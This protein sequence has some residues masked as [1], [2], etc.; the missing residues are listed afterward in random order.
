LVQQ[1]QTNVVD[2][3]FPIVRGQFTLDLRTLPVRG[4][5]GAPKRMVKLFD[6]TC[7]HCRDLH[8][9][10][11]PMGRKYSNDLAIVSLPMPL[12]ANCNPML[13]ST[14]RAH[15][16]AC[17]YAR[18]ALAVFYADRSKFEEF[19]DWLYLPERPPEVSEAR[20]HAASM[21]GR[22]RLEAAL[23]DARIDGQIRTNAFIYAASSRLGK[24]SALP[25][26]IFQ[27]G[28]SIGAVADEAQLEK[29]LADALGLR[30]AQTNQ[31]AAS[32]RSDL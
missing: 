21:V 29:I 22:E 14:A 25:Q 16:D 12:N 6:Y 10:L 15:I 32:S 2:P 11:E 28:A 1:A 3:M 30:E 19:S 9:L 7:H 26:L 8:H 31:A 24:S 4:S 5:L 13:R 20:E 17:E 27:N 23:G 18:L